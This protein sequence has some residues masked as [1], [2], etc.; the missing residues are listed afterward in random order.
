MLL[1][2]R[3]LPPNTDLRAVL[4]DELN[5]LRSE[6]W[7]VEEGHSST[8]AAFFAQCGP[9]RIGV[10]IERVDP[11]QPAALDNSRSVD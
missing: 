6:G 5:R 11:T 3:T 4:T 2:H 7:H 10:S 1:E 8:C 9:D